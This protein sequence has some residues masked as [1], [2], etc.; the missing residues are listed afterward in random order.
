MIYNILVSNK[1]KKFL[2]HSISLKEIW[3]QP[4]IINFYNQ[5][6]TLKLVKNVQVFLNFYIYL[7]II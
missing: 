7:V 6:A 2:I 1:Q 5:M 4:D 3:P